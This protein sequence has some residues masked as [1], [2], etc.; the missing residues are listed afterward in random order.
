MSWNQRVVH[1]KYIHKDNSIE[2]WYEI[3]EVYYDK[4]SNIDGMTKNPI[5]PM[6]HTIEDLK[7]ELQRMIDCLE[8]PILEYDDEE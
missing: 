7:T 6:G 1:R 3:H 8:K 4:K 2:E 5:C